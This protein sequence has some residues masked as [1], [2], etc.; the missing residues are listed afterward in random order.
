MF[1]FFQ[2]QT[3]TNLDTKNFGYLKPNTYYFD[4]A[5]QSLR[6]QEVIDA[7][8][9]YYQSYNSCGHRVKYR[10]GEITDQLV[11]ETRSNLLK[12]VSK[13]AKDYTVAFGLNTTSGINT[14]LFQLPT[15]RFDKIITSEIEHNSVFLPSLTWSQKFNKPRLVLKRATDGS[16]EYS[17]N[18]LTKAIVLLNS[19]SNI[20]GRNLVN[21]KQLSQDV[22][23]AGGIILLDSCQT[24]GHNWDFL[25]DID[26][27]AAF[28]AGHKMYGP[29]LGFTIIKTELVKQL[30][31]YLIGGSTVQD[32]DLD[33]F[34][35]I[36]DEEEIYARIEPGLQNYGGIIGLNTAIKWKQSFS[37]TINGKTLKALEY[38]DYLAKYLNEKLLQIPGI[39]LLN[40]EPSAVVSLYADKIDGHKL[41]IFLSEAGIMCRSGYHC[42]HYYLKKVLNLPPL[43]RIS[44]GLN[45]DTDQI[46]YLIEKLKLVVK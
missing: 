7:Q 13:S 15:N 42:C 23:K 34:E 37:K 14:V 26:F 27:D 22:H 16:L 1:K 20:D 44:L 28:G 35:L 36:S 9:K 19:T 29:S 40:T 31:C 4:S 5:C 18:D 41:A 11:Q 43:F 3:K 38:E 46:D 10:W 33:T 2:S 39:T 8:N 32:V 30:D 25:K 17:K 12:L 21:L 45:N 24:F 6:P